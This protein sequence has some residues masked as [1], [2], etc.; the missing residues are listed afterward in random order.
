MSYPKLCADTLKFE[1]PGSK[2]KTDAASVLKALNIYSCALSEPGYKSIEHFTKSN[3]P[4]NWKIKK[5]K[6]IA[7]RKRNYLFYFLE[8]ILSKF[9]P[10]L[11]VYEVIYFFEKKK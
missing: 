11:F 8:K 6:Y 9:F 10:G 7:E 1:Y 2:I 3:T 5:Y 4:D